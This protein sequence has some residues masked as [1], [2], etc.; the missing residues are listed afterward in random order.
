MIIKKYNKAKVTSSK[1]GWAPPTSIS[2]K[3][4]GPRPHVFSAVI[5]EKLIIDNGTWIGYSG[6]SNNKWSKN[7]KNN[8]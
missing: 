6:M 1:H 4:G 7:E 5:Q 8:S 3:Q 2:S